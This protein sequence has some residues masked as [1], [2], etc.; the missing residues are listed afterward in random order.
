MH[1]NIGKSQQLQH[2]VVQLHE[3]VPPLLIS[4]LLSGLKQWSRTRKGWTPSKDLA[5]AWK[6]LFGGSCPF[7][8]ELRT[9]YESMAGGTVVK[10]YHFELDPKRPITIGSKTAGLSVKLPVLGLFVKDKRKFLKIG[11]C[12]DARRLANS[13]LTEKIAKKQDK[14]HKK[15]G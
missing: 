3:D 6:E 11:G 14:K 12:I 13:M 2:V 1:D 15:K 10:K 9:T 8:F 5:A 7:P 4:T